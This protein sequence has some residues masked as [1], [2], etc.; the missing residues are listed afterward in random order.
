MKYLLIVSIVINVI[1]GM[2]ILAMRISIKELR[3]DFAERAELRSN[4][5][6]GVSSRDK[7]IRL[8]A[9][10]INDTLTKLRDAFNKY[11]LG[12]DEVKTAI[13]NI[14]HD[15]RTPLTS[16]L[17]YLELSERLDKSPEME[18]YLDI[19][20][21]RAEHMK[22]LTEELFEYSVIT[23]GEIRE[24]KT[25]VNVNKALEDCI[26]SN[27]PALQ[28][29]GIEPVVEIT[30]TPIVRKLYP[31]YV[32]RIMNNLVNNALKYSDGDLEVKLSDSGKLTVA[33][34]AQELSNVEV[35]KLFDR[36]FTVENARNN[37][38]GLGLSIVKV[39]AERMNLDLSADYVDGKI[40]IEID[41]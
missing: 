21:D 38:T 18:K 36:F 14:A 39:F 9:T 3:I 4:T 22:K 26:M 7:Q 27:Y 34:S 11:K 2:K 25:K 6:L 29:R 31:S 17:G 28:S 15:L 16:I 12:D 20:K 13:T 33:N 37:S 1:L 41:F 35:N 5:L 32:E 10:S 23:G 40:V 19:I 30:E 8:L 24:E